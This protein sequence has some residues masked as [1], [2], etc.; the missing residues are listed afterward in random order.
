MGEHTVNLFYEERGIGFPIILVHGFPLDRTIWEPVAGYLEPFSRVICPD[1]RGYGRSP[2]ADGYRME[3][4]AGDLVALMD[5]LGIESAILAGHSMGGYISL[6]FARDY[7][8]RLAGLALVTSQAAADLP[9]RREARYQL[10]SEVE[11]RGVEAVVDASL[12][13]YSP[14]PDVLAFTKTLMLKASPEVVAGSLRGM[15]ERSDMTGLL[16]KL[17]LPALIIAGE[18]DELIAPRRSEEMAGLLPQGELVVIPGGGHMA[19]IEAPRLVADALHKL[20]SR[21]SGQTLAH[22]G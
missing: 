22:N 1:L 13:K 12:A 10:A 2:Q 11:K 19:M 5:R 15:A 16:E 4:F 17:D 18:V 8:H 21:V 20:I 6:A 9:E 3:S 14:N 7:P